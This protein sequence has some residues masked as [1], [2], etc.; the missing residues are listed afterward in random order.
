MPSTT[1]VPAATPVRKPPLPRAIYALFLIRLVV[2]AGSFVHVL[3]VMILTGRLGWSGS[4]AGVFMSLVAGLSGVGS[5]LG[6]KLGDAFGRRRVLALL[7]SLAAAIFLASAVVGYGPWTPALAA[8]ALALL[9]GSW[10]SINALVADHAPP[11][12][13]REAFSLLY[14][15]NNVGFSVGPALAGFLYV[16]AP[17]ALF[18]GN[19]LAL[20][21]AAATATLFVP[22]LAAGRA[23]RRSGA[24]A[25]SLPS[26]KPDPSTRA[27]GS[28]GGAPV[29]G[30]ASTL[31]VFRADPVLSAYGL[32]AVLTAF[33]YDQHRFA[34]PLTLKE[35]F[36]EALGAQAFTWAMSVN[37]LTVVAATAL[38]TLASRRLPSLAAVALGSVFYALGF[39]AYGWVSGVPAFLG[40]TAFWTLGEIL[41][42]TNGNAF[43]AERA[44]ESHRGRVNGALSL[45]YIMGGVLS[46]LVAGPLADAFGA[47]AV[48]APIALTSALGALG[49]FALSA[50]NRARGP[51]SL[52]ARAERPAPAPDSGSGQA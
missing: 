26:V 9:S 31:A 34:L 25:S 46:P 40:V 11:E 35:T 28:A 51:G 41:G 4:A 52:P 20:L 48:W 27:D 33:V 7:Q 6:G 8:V 37:G 16:H 12:R 5:L 2:S 21:L 15:G 49:L 3:L 36:G 32:L 19:A 17:R 42:A 14:W 13:R 45:A 24:A 39:G 38:V 1:E 23:A 43:V 50:W 47:R 22:E 18:A 30:R 10:P 29:L 44:P